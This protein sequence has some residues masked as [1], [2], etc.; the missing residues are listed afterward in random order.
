M[1][2]KVV[3]GEDYLTGRFLD[4]VGDLE[5]GAWRD[6]YNRGCLLDFGNIVLKGRI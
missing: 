6:S 5:W 2:R 4:V 1:E 3:V